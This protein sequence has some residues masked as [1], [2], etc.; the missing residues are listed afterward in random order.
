[1]SITV[2]IPNEYFPKFRVILLEFIKNKKRKSIVKSRI[3][4][5]Y[6]LGFLWY[7][8]STWSCM[9]KMAAVHNEYYLKERIYAKKSERSP[10]KKEDTK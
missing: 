2:N 1:L 3:M 4:E 7:E 10:Y 8:R 9:G 5:F 6:A